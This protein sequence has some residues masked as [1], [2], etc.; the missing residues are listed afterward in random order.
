MARYRDYDYCQGKFIPLCFD[1]QILTGTFEYVPIP[2]SS[3][4]VSPRS[5]HFRDLPARRG[6]TLA[7]YVPPRYS[8]MS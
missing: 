7:Q 3:Q 8:S 1:K 5:L 4:Y 2:E 6:G